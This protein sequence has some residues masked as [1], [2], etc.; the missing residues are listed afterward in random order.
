[1]SSVV[2]SPHEIEAGRVILDAQWSPDFSNYGNQPSQGPSRMRGDLQLAPDVLGVSGV[3][4]SVVFGQELRIRVITS[5]SAI[6]V[7]ANYPPRL[8]LNEPGG[9]VADRPLSTKSFLERCRELLQS[10]R[11]LLRSHQVL[12]L[13]RQLSSLLSDEDELVESGMTVLTAS[14]DGLVDFLAAHR[15]HTHPSLSLTRNGRFAASWSPYIRAKLTL[16]FTRE[17]ADWVGVDLDATTPV[18]DR[19][20]VLISS[21]NGMP[22][23]FRSWIVD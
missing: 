3:G 4:E 21:L 23:P 15:P 17:A 22:L 7:G 19:G 16:T 1:V 8:D 9:A 20:V 5:T 6:S 10:R 11:G 14:L 12:A 13:E 2:F 18:R